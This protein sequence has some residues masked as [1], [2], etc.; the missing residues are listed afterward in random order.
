MD[1]KELIANYPAVGNTE[2]HSSC[3]DRYA[4]VNTARVVER[5][6]SEGWEI[7]GG[8]Q[9]RT[10]MPENAQFARH[11]VLLAKKGDDDSRIRGRAY[12]QLMNAHAGRGS[13]RFR[14]GIYTFACANECLS[15]AF[16]DIK[17]ESRHIGNAEDRMIEAFYQI[18]QNMPA[19]TAR[20][21]EWAKFTVNYAQARELAEAG[22]T[23]RFGEDRAKWAIDADT[24]VR[25]VRRTEDATTDL[26]SVYNRV[27]ENILRPFQQGRLNED[28]GRRIPFRK[29]S[30][31][32]SV[33]QINTAL[34]N[35][36]DKLV[37][38][39]S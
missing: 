5:I 1:I 26:W 38:L 35:T 29:V 8:R 10:R 6:T 37:G 14:A 39:V 36:A 28:T 17:I 27:Q 13:A 4:L 3:S 33:A 16:L 32:D 15:G 31:L 2:I 23:A 11:S 25:N 12:T 7:I 34:W 19:L 22:L 24:V 9:A 20:V 30:A 18:A 21:S